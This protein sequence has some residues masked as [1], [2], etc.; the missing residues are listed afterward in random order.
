MTEEQAI[1]KI[2]AIEKELLDIKTKARE[3]RTKT[4]YRGQHPKSVGFVVADFVVEKDVPEDLRFGVFR[5]ARGPI[6]GGGPFFE[7]PQHGRLED[8][9]ARYDDQALRRQGGKLMP[10]RI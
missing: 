2:I 10:T 1:E 7:R 8:R 4:M 5:R 9:R 6:W 3:T